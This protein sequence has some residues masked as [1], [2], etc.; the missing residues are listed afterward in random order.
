[1]N[2]ISPA[3][4]RALAKLGLDGPQLAGVLNVLADMADG[5]Q[6]APV[7]QKHHVAKP[8]PETVTEMHHVAKAG[9][10]ESEVET[11]G[12]VRAQPVRGQKAIARH[13]IGS[14]TGMPSSVARVADILIDCFNLET[15]RCDPSTARIA[16]RCGLS[17]RSVR[18]ATAALDK[19]GLIVMRQH[20]GRAHCNAYVPDWDRLAALANADNWDAQP[21]QDLST[22]PTLAANLD[23]SGH[24]NLKRK[25]Y[26]TNSESG[27]DS[28]PTRGEVR[29]PV[30]AA[31]KKTKPKRLTKPDRRQG[32]LKMP[33]SGGRSV[34][35]SEAMRDAATR[36]LS[37]DIETRC[38]RATDYQKTMTAIL[39]LPTA[40]IEE[41]NTAE[42]KRQGSGW[43]VI[44]RGLSAANS[45]CDPPIIRDT[46]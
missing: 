43:F 8:T 5:T 40:V 10:V 2:C 3:H 41:A 36:R 45:G 38:R 30:L 42:T 33:I 23:R 13:A 15:G 27:F 35:K 32:Y 28:A 24:Q 31:A 37:V 4:L 19:A 21:G 26:K 46:G 1:M 22:W 44:E 14:I 6:T 12:Q 17:R 20:G 18:R 9:Q 7:A 25:P 11:V 16:R 34:D 39:D 29:A